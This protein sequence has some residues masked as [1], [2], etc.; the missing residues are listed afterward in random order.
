MGIPVM[1]APCSVW[2]GPDFGSRCVIAASGFADGTKQNRNADPSSQRRTY[3]QRRIR[4]SRWNKQTENR[5]A[6]KTSC[7]QMLSSAVSSQGRTG[8]PDR[9]SLLFSFF[10]ASSILLLL[11]TTW[12]FYSPSASSFSQR[13]VSRNLKRVQ[14]LDSAFYTQTWLYDWP[15]ARW[16]N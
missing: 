9:L 1:L 12:S 7:A 3:P 6:D 11:V 2:F 4:Y 8:L 16:E 10:C 14:N 5:S 13:V 15:C